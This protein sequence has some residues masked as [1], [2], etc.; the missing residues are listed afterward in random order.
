[1]RT[2]SRSR[3]ARAPRRSSEASSGNCRVLRLAADRP[4]AISCR[5]AVEA[6]ARRRQLRPPHRRS[7]RI[8]A[9]L[10]RDLEPCV[11]DQWRQRTR[12]LPVV[13]ARRV[14]AERVRDDAGVVLA[15]AHVHSNASASGGRHAIAGGGGLAFAWTPKFGASAYQV[16]VATTPDF[17]HGV[18][19]TTVEGPIYAPTLGGGYPQERTSLLAGRDG[20]CRRHGGTFQQAARRVSSQTRRGMSR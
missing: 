6:D 8:G 14:P 9:R 12:A 7:R 2:A 17:S 3:G 19:S 18:D 5:R 10:H 16:Q 15:V 13:C 1:M 4:R 11:G 20:Q